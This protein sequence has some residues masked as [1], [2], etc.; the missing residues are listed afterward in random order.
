MSEF[1]LQSA[2]ERLNEAQKRAVNRTKGPMLIV[3][4]AGS[5]KTSVLTTRIATLLAAGENPERILALTFTKKAAEEMRSRVVEM[6][7]DAAKRL[8][9]G[10]F[11][12]VFMRFLRQHA[13]RI[14]YPTS[15]T[16]L[17][18]EDSLNTLKRC[19]AAVVEEGRP[20][21]EQWTDVQEKIYKAIDANYKPKTVS[22][23]ISDS[24]NR[25]ITA[26][27][28]AADPDI[29]ERDR[30]LG[31][32]LLGKIFV[33][34][35]NLCHR[36]AMMD[37]DD[38][39]LYTDMLLNNCP[40]VAAALAGSFDYIL[41]DEYQDTNSAQ[42]SILR[43]LTWLNDNICVVGDDSQSIYAFRGAQIQNI[44]SFR[45]DYPGCEVVKLEQNYRSTRTIVDAA[46]RLIAHNSQRI[47][48]TCYSGAERGSQIR[49]KECETEAHEAAYIAATIKGKKAQDRM[50]NRDFAILFRT[51]AQSRALEDALV[52][53]RIPY[54]IYSGTSFFERMEIKDMMAY[55]KLAVNP[56]DD[57]SFRRVVNKPV[58]G[59]GDAA[60]KKLTDLA[61]KM[62]KSLWDTA[63]SPELD[64]N[65]MFTRKAAAGLLAFVKQ[66]KENLATASQSD[67]F[68]AAMEISESSG[69]IRMFEAEG[70]KE[71]KSRADNIRELLSAVR[72][73]E[74]ETR[75]MNADGDL[76][77]PTDLQ[78]FI[79]NAM[80]MS[81]ADTDDGS[82]DKV[83]LMTVHSAKG[84]EFPC[85]FI[86]G[87]EEDLFPLNAGFGEYDEEEERRLCYVAVTRAKKQ[88]IIT[89]AKKR[90][91]FGRRVTCK[92]SRFIGEL[93]AEP[94]EQ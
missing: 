63:C 68:A 57:E 73:F 28:Y 64:K 69:L 46:N 25:L 13:E 87:M 71:A 62:N 94:A 12:S 29:A 47:P 23:V 4:G 43:R 88:L 83:S 59:F 66:V 31:R 51:N 75:K 21:R 1:N 40:G 30:Y 11:H 3:A 65:E 19:I 85:V 52:K 81:N 26:D 18:E 67:A 42:Y 36:M 76:P 77:E 60:L 89:S 32:P 37:F 15:F 48:K 10:T 84:L 20:P 8:C 86:A 93:A 55:F 41:V 17:D 9:M 70:D 38:I 74:E 80:L 39:L 72:S 53:A 50:S 61:G 92:P 91:R 33:E 35:R 22:A 49:V 54:V 45:N 82:D 14:Y 34:Y 24:K 90:M 5:G 79:Q 6:C 44:F 58:R 7:G 27:A 56:H 16:I 2:V 78:S